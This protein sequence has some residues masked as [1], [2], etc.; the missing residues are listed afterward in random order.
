MKD[1]AERLFQRGA[2]YQNHRPDYPDSLFAALAQRAPARRLALDLGCGSGQ[3][4]RALGAHFQQVLGADVSLEQLRAAPPGGAHYLA[5]RADA[6]PLADASLDLITVAQAL[7]WFPLPAFF[8]EAGRV[9]R[10]GG[11]LAIISYGLCMVQG[12][13]GLVEDFH[14][15]T[16]R[17]WWP[18]A[19]WL[20]VDGYRGLPLPW[21]EL[22]DLATAPIRRQ[23]GWRDMAGY[24]D[25]WSALVSARAAGED[26]LAAFVPALRAAWGEGKRTVCW[27]LRVRCCA[28]P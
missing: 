7:H 14:D 18:A 6:L 21:P 16:L 8:H 20:V 28:R 27:P 1:D 11:V 5:A 13:E 4:C 22:P 9:L 12:L 19:R 17:P 2:R 24:L 26:P 23:W 15:R 3:A 10:P 25:T